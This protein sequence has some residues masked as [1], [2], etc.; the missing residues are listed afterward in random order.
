MI[1]SSNYLDF[2]PYP[3]F[4][5]EQ[6]KIIEQIQNSASFRKNILFVAPNGTGKTIIALSPLLPVALERKLKIVY[7]C[8]TR[9]QSDRVIKELKKI[10]KSAPDGFITI[11]ILY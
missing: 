2:F 1:K 11:V 5:L 10:Y 7:M 3:T 6:E 4:R 8:R 9:A